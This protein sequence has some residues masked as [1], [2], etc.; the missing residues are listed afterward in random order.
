MPCATGPSTKPSSASATS[1][2]GRELLDARVRPA[3]EN[4]A[5]IGAAAYRGFGGNDGNVPAG[6]GGAG[7]LRTGFD[8]PDH[9][10]GADPGANRLQSDGGCG[11]A[12]D[13]RH[14]MPWRTSASAAC[15]A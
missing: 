5:L 12:G 10:H 4:R 6:G 2:L 11:I 9:R 15:I 8:D 3:R 7:S 1:S 14:L 13:D